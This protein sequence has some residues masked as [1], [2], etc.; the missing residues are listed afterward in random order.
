[1]APSHVIFFVWICDHV[2][3]PHY[4]LFFVDDEF[5]VTV[6]DRLF[7]EPYLSTDPYHQGLILHAVYHRPNGWDYVPEGRVVHPNVPL[8]VVQG[9]LTMAQILEFNFAALDIDYID[10]FAIELRP[11]L[12][13][14]ALPQ[15]FAATLPSGVTVELVGLCVD[16]GTAGQQ[17][18]AA[19][20]SSLPVNFE[21]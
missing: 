18:W 2:V 9:P 11:Y 3:E 20:G 12:S 4:F 17:W 21:F 16:P 14:D 6:A 8:T 19:A 13:E 15:T 5:P 10:R 1:M 7:A